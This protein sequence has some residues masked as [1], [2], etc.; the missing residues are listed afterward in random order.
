MIQKNKL[1]NIFFFCIL[2]AIGGFTFYMFLPFMGTLILAATCAVVLHPIHKKFVKL[3]NGLTGLSALLT[4]TLGLIIVLIPLIFFSIRI[5]QETA[6]VYSQIQTD[7]NT[8]SHI[9]NDIILKSIHTKLPHFKID[10]DDLV[11]QL[12]TWLASH[13]GGFFTGT[14]E[15]ILHFIIFTIAVFYLLKDGL[16]LKQEFIHLSPL[17]N[18]FDAEIYTRLTKAMRSILM[19]SLL[20]SIIQGILMGIGL[21][22][23]G[24]PNATLWGSITAICSLIPGIGTSLVWIPAVIYIYATQSAGLAIG[25]LIWSL[26]IVSLVDN[27]L[28]PVLVAR[29]VNIHPFFILMSVLSGLAFFGPAG[30]IFGPLLLSL[31]FALIDI[32]KILVKPS[33]RV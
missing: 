13:V 3:F 6:D 23:F 25:L 5:F 12:V 11:K 15:S 30:F 24:V 32:Y 19:G 1:Q 22:L 4:M 27:F 31:L 33:A 9:V 2:I 10:I 18:E 7:Q 29:G 28:S 21:A 14:V 16:Q 8:V 17:K 26:I 20:V